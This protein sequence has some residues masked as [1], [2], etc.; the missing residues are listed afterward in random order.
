MVFP[1][2]KADPGP[3]NGESWAVIVGVSD[4]LYSNI[5]RLPDLHYCDDDAIDLF[6]QLAPT[7]GESHLKLLTDSQAN[8]TSIQDAIL[9]WLDPLENENDTVLFF[10]AGQGGQGNDVAPLDEVDGKDEYIC[11]HDSLTSSYSNDIRDDELEIWLNNLESSKITIILDTCH[12]GGF[13]ESMGSTKIESKISAAEDDGTPVN[14]NDGFAKDISKS[15]RVILAAC[16]EN[17]NSWEVGYFEHSVFSNYILEAMN[18]LDIVD[19]SAKH[20]ML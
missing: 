7:W 19:T 10:F 4:Y 14:Q 11:P 12:S 17:E 13:I 5:I 18:R 9:N 3:S 6:N 20:Q 2:A 1:T 16:A 8:K 15:G